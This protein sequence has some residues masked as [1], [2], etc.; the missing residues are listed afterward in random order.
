[1]AIKSKRLGAVA[2]SATT[3]T[4]LYQVPTG[5]Q[6]TVSVTACNRGSSSGTFRVALVDGA[7]GSVANED[8][9][10]YDTALGP[11]ESLQLGPFPVDAGLSFLVRASTAN[12]SFVA[13]GFEGDL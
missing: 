9:V 8:Y 10:E 7:I 1:M 5:K 12:F 11:N 3:D 2:P 6:A 13:T 4:S